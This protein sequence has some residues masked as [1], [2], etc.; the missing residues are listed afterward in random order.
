MTEYLNDGNYVQTCDY[1][2]YEPLYDMFD[3]L[4]DIYD[5]EMY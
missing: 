4:D 2:I 5:Q 1:D 3:E